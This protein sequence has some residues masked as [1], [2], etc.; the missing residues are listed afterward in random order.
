M[1]PLLQWNVL[2]MMVP[3]E[4]I[5]SFRDA[6]KWLEYFPPYGRA[7]VAAFGSSVDW[8]RCISDVTRTD[9][10]QCSLPIIPFP[11]SYIVAFSLITCRRSFITTS[12]NPFYD[13]FIRWQF[14]KLQ[15]GGRIKFGKRANVYS[16]IDQQV[17]CSSIY[18]GYR[19]TGTSHCTTQTSLD[20]FSDEPLVQVCADHDRQT[21]EGI[22]PQEYTIIKLKVLELRGKPLH[23]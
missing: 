23:L 9:R 8:R 1:H 3:E 19:E 10:M 11:N 21:G 6:N 22:G 17:V 16:I 5:P 2:K 15:D 4:E 13:S 20:V 12:A 18:G 7:D 14:R